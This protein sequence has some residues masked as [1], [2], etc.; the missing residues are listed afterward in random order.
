MTHYPRFYSLRGPGVMMGEGY[1]IL[2]LEIA[3]YV[4]TG[5]RSKLW[6]VFTLSEGL[7]KRGKE[8]RTERDRGRERVQ[9]L[10]DDD[11][12]LRGGG[13]EMGRWQLSINLGLSMRMRLAVTAYLTLRVKLWP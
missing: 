4:L 2:V 7:K 13:G 8:G 9:Q 5:S 6:A 3:D 10:M 1:G 11:C 12:G